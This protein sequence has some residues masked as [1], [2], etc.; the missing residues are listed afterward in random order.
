MGRTQDTLTPFVQGRIHVAV[1]GTNVR[2]D[3]DTDFDN[4]PEQSFVARNLP[5]AA[6]GSLIGLG[7]FG[8][9]IMDNFATAAP[10]TTITKHPRKRTG[11]TTAR[12][13]F[14]SSL[15]GSTF[16]CKLDGRRYKRC[17]SPKTYHNLSLGRH[18]FRV[19]A[20]DAFG[21][22]DAT[23]AKFSWRIR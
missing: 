17:S 16:R 23:P 14:K 8:G 15:A 4:R 6:L 19:R 5:T 22:V 18:T 12:F 7:N 10:Q 21:N 3:I 9:A 20:K 13:K 11:H 1:F 2:L